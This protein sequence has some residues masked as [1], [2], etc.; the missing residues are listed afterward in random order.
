MSDA[1]SAKKEIMKVVSFFAERDSERNRQMY[2]DSSTQFDNDMSFHI[3]C[4]LWNKPRTISTWCSHLGL[5]VYCLLI[6]K[7]LKCRGNSS[8]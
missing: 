6:K 3:K 8:P 4:E 5:E 1:G 7:V 2:R